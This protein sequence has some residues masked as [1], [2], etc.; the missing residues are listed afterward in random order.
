MNIYFDCAL[1]E[2][3]QF[4]CLPQM[5]KILPHQNLARTAGSAVENIIAEN[6]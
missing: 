4:F 5:S 3:I 2:Q 6:V 1:T